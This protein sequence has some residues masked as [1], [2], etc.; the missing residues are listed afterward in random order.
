M[1]DTVH[2]V[3]ALLKDASQDFDA[4]PHRG[5]D[6]HTLPCCD[7]S[8]A[9]SAHDEKTLRR[10]RRRDK[11]SLFGASSDLHRAASLFAQIR[12]DIFLMSKSSCI[13]G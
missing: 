3:T 10:I 6:K 8:V 2:L 11:Q 7:A 4:D 9:V 1:Q 13:R 5:A 12:E